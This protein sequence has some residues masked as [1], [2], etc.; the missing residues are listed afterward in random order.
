MV[1]PIVD[2]Q[3]GSQGAQQRCGIC[4]LLERD[5]AGS[6]VESG[7]GEP[8]GGLTRQGGFAHAS[9]AMDHHQF[10]LQERPFDLQE[11]KGTSAEAIAWF[12]RHVL[13]EHG[14]GDIRRR[15]LARS[16]WREWSSRSG[17]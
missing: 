11:F 17:L 8:V 10:L 6:L 15:L 1:V 4:A 9:K 5:E 14:Q 12:A 7:A 2:A 3:K 13:A 16:C